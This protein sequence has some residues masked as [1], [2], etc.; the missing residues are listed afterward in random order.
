MKRLSQDE[1]IIKR[2][3]AEV[4]E[5]DYFG[6]KVLYL[7][8]GT[9][10]KLF[11]RKRLISYSLFFPYS[12]KFALNA[13]RLKKLGVPTVEVISVYYIPSISRTAVHYR[14]LE[15]CVFNSPSLDFT[16]TLMFKFGEFLRYLHDN[17]VYFRSL[18]FSNV[19]LT[20]NNSIGLIDIADTRFLA[21]PLSLRLRIRNFKHIL[22]YIEDKKILISMLDFFVQGYQSR[23]KS[24]VSNQILRDMCMKDFDKN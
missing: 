19:I 16:D 15:G 8:D 23:G 5:A 20:P 7:S 11:R 10:L 17:G 21:W 2:H 13:L 6:D 18:H 14:P 4:V 3:K 12:K 24:I 9:Y 1:Y 22:R